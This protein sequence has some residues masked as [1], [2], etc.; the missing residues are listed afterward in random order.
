MSSQSTIKCLDITMIEKPLARGA[1]STAHNIAHLENT[2]R[3]NPD[4]LPTIDVGIV[5]GKYYPISGFDVL[6]ACKN[7]LIRK[8]NV[9]IKEYDT[10]ADIIISHMKEMSGGDCIDPLRIRGVVD[11]L[12]MFGISVEDALEKINQKGT[13]LGQIVTS[14]IADEVLNMFAKFIDEKLTDKLQPEAAMVPSPIIL[15]LA[16]LG[17]TTS[18]R[19]STAHSSASRHPNH[20]QHSAGRQ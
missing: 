12:G 14:K 5:N 20:S 18:N 15:K 4:N 16:T 13:I 7:A 11:E 3:S 17:R 2:A 10:K 19:D 9:R 6:Q 1:V 8:I